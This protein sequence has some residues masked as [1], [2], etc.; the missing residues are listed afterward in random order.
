MSVPGRNRVNL[1]VAEYELE[2]LLPSSS[3]SSFGTDDE[4]RQRHQNEY[5]F[6]RYAEEVSA[7]PATVPGDSAD[8]AGQ[9]AGGF[10]DVR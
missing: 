8:Q 10:L 9:P 4:K 6:A 2:D 7:H 3:S 5:K 1:P